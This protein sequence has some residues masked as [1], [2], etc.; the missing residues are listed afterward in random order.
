MFISR[1]FSEKLAEPI[2]TEPPPEALADPDEAAVLPPPDGLLEL[3]HAASTSAA[4]AAVAPSAYFLIFISVLSGDSVVRASA[5][6]LLNRV[7]VCSQV[8]CAHLARGSDAQT[9]PLRDRC[10]G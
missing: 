2:V 1:T 3:P 8:S 9:P 5:L 6:V 4:N 10:D 7:A